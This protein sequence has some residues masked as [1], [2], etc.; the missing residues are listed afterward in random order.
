MKTLLAAAIATLALSGAA[1]AK[2]GKDPFAVCRADLE[3]LC[4][5][6]KPG[7]GRQVKCMME[8]RAGASGEC[9]TIL[10]KKA[11][12]EAQHSQGKPNKV[13]HQ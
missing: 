10:N 12:K 3:R 5:D 9:A 11:E 1:S 2:D 4:G 7:E 6:V 8:K 13:K